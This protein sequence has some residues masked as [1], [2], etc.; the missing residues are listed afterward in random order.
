[1][2]EICEIKTKEIKRL[3]KACQAKDEAISKATKILRLLRSNYLSDYSAI[4][5]LIKELE[6]SKG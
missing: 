5:K 6:E 1:M 2:C 3:H 4:T